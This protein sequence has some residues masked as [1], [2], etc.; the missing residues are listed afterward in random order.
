MT[1]QP[2]P[3]C[4]EL[5]RELQALR[6]RAGLSLTAL[7]HRTSASKSSWHRYLRGTK[8][9][10]RELVR[11]LCELA[12][13]QPG[14]VL[15]LHERAE[16]A[17]SGPEPRDGARRPAPA[18]AATAGEPDTAREAEAERTGQA[19]RTEQA[20]KPGKETAHSPV[21]TST[22]TADEAAAD[23]GR[24]RG[25]GSSWEHPTLRRWWRPIAA[26][27]LLGSA[28]AVGVNAVEQAID[29][30]RRTVSPPGCR[31]AGCTGKDPE[32][33][34]CTHAEY[35]PVSVVERGFSG[36]VRMD[37]RHSKGCAASWARIWLAD[38]GTRIVIRSPEGDVQEA[39]IRDSYD[40]QGYVYTPMIGGVSEGEVEACFFAP[41]DG[42]SPGEEN[43]DGSPTPSQTSSSGPSV[44]AGADPQCF[45][46]PR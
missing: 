46:A 34:G 7:A 40:A 6:D 33:Q 13:E 29:K 31:G 30:A 43:R 1:R 38:V 16:A 39:S 45:T 32:S 25:S 36:G 5:A 18:S 44:A 11:E 27:V 26:G 20:A 2:P 8:L 15:A 9:P 17:R 19:E 22:A 21:P 14:R 23:A 24:T 42:D 37:I 35:E 41:S 4:L 3:E 12:R 10:T 28:V